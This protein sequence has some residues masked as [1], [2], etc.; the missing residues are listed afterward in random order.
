[1]TGGSGQAFATG[2]KLR[3]ANQLPALVKISALFAE[4]ILTEGFPV[5]PSPSQ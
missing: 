4:T 5:I 3:Y 1:M 2:G